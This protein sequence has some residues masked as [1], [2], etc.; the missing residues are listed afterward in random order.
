MKTA[1]FAKLLAPL[2]GLAL[3][4]G[5]NKSEDPAKPAAAS[6]PSSYLETIKARDK[7][8][9]GVFT[10]KPPFGFVDESGRYVGFDTDIG[11]RFAK[12]LL[13]DENKVEFVAVEPASRIPFLQSD[14]VDLILANM[15]VTPER[16][17]AVDFTNPNLRVAVQA[18][19]ADG[20]PV[21]KL[22]DLADKTI[23]VTT[24]TTADIWL[25]K[26]HPDWKLLKFEKNT[27]SLA[28][29]ANGRGDAYAQD[30]LILFSWA[31]QNPGYR[32]LPQLLG[33]EA[34]IAPAVKK[35]NTELRDW[36][37]TEL[38]KLGEEKFLLKLYD[39]Y[40]R[41]ELSDDTKPES[42]IVEG[43]KWQG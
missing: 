18:I 28:A 6:P 38:A 33:D 40:V 9:V 43:G 34:P 29:L 27:E 5:C 36:V 37:N 39:Q 15:T 14:K 8:I 16:K 17:E 30:N 7:L 35:G 20:S 31:K 26:T 2:L 24:G 25:T 21:Q 23:I 32:V 10:D 19:V 42:V 3:L 22:D 12:D 13:G 4:A 41:K 1:P 11:R